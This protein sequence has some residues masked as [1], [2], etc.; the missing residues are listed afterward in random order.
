MESC[1]C[2]L[3]RNRSQFEDI[4]FCQLLATLQVSILKQN[5]SKLWVLK[6]E[7]LG[8]R[9]STTVLHNEKVSYTCKDSIFSPEC[10]AYWSR[11]FEVLP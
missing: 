2:A 7:I 1:F 5:K 8:N 11:W 6:E 4:A 9:I 3:L 10:L